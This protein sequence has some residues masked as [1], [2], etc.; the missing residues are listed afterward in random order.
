[1]EKRGVRGQLLLQAEIACFLAEIPFLQADQ[2]A[3]H[4]VV[5][6]CAGRETFDS[7][8]NHVEIVQQFVRGGEEIGGP[9]LGPG[10]RASI[11]CQNQD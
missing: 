10:S 5:E 2:R 8:D 1:M 11:I 3:A 6:I 4:A 9:V 7:M